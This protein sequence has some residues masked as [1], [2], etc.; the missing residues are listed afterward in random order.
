MRG[1]FAQALAVVAACIAAT[2]AGCTSGPPAPTPASSRATA[3]AAAPSGRSGEL[4]DDERLLV[5]RAQET[6]VERCMRAKGFPYWPAPLPPADILHGNGYVVDDI[7]WA[8][9]NGYGTRLRETF[10]ARQRTNR[11]DAYAN[12]LSPADSGRYAKALLGGPTGSM[13]TA[14]LP[15]GQRIRTPREGCRAE[16]RDRLYGDFPTWFRVEKTATS[17]T[18]LYL[19]ALLRD[20]RFVAAQEA[21]ATCMRRAGHDYATP[22]AAREGLAERAKGLSPARA[23]TVEVELAV[24]EATCASRT[25]LAATAR[26]L[27]A[28]YRATGL[29]RYG[30][31]LATYHRMNRTAL[32][33][34]EEITG[35][36]G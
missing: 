11:N 16:A 22:P 17:L 9:R 6:L 15:G 35:S 33:N 4:T 5:Q 24:A 13:L 26:A 18:G 30:D 34:A 20:R 8:R 2:T 21:W 32:A 31:D 7:G 28:E 23:H 10:L 29:Q 1:T 27:D 36:S 25:P 14:E 3:P 12:T 19:P